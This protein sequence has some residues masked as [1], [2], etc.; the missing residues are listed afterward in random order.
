MATNNYHGAKNFIKTLL[1]EVSA[2]QLSGVSWMADA[3][4]ARARKKMLCFIMLARRY[5]SE[6]RK[7]M[8]VLWNTIGSQKCVKKISGAE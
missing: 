3:D 5:G 2:S 1:P 4:D 8:V 6:G 7:F